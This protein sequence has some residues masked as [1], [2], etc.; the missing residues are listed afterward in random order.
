AARP[1]CIAE[2]CQALLV[3]G[4][5]RSD[6]SKDRRAACHKRTTTHAQP[7]SQ[8]VWSEATK[9]KA[10]GQPAWLACEV[11]FLLCRSYFLGAMVSFTAL[12]T[13][14]FTTVLAAILMGSPVWG[15][16][17]MRA[18][19]FDFTNRPRPGMTNTPFF[20]VSLIAV[21]ARCSRNAAAV[22]LF[23]SSFSA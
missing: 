5:E 13:R 23:V 9:I 19:R 17:P 12:A 2:R 14:N 21:S 4:L 18:F 3:G 15:F 16:R 10:K 20:L 7:N 6:R 1:R 11:L 22:L 8:A